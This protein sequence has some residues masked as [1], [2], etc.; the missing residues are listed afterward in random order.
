MKPRI[1]AVVLNY[2]QADAACRAAH[3]LRSSEGVDVDVLVVDSNSGSHD[4]A[5]LN[6]CAGADRLLLLP[7][8]RGYA[9][10]MNAGLQWWRAH[11]GSDAIMLVTPDARIT[12]DVASGLWYA[13]HSSADIAASGPV[14][15][16]RDGVDRKIGAGGYARDGR[17]FQHH[18][19]ESEEP[20]DVDW[21]EGCCIMLRM[22]AFHA[23]GGFEESYF[24]YYEEL[25]LC[26][27]LRHAGWR[28]Q[29][30]PS[31]TV[32]HPKRLGEQPSHYYYYMTRNT[33]VYWKKFFTGASAGLT[34]F[35]SAGRLGLIAAAVTVI[36]WK[37][38]QMR[39]RW[40]D[41]ARATR[42][43]WSGTLDYL[44]GVSGPGPMHRPR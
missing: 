26:A 32:A 41:F 14:I 24:L 23:V 15:L 22:E 20:Y 10:G 35:R 43:A 40:R 28:I 37:W 18:R 33:Y 2:K 7:D 8:N 11:G 6:S 31:I 5:R 36:P 27:R 17:V 39:A 34:V 21:I 3:E 29:L 16:Y 4:H 13:L 12:A 19:V 42:G 44:K 1:C 9:G 25:D 38:H 30:V